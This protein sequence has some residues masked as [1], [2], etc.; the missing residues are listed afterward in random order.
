VKA[1]NSTD[2]KGF[3]QNLVF[4]KGEK[5]R[6]IEDSKRI[7]ILSLL[8][9]DMEDRL[10]RQIEGNN[11]L[12]YRKAELPA[13]CSLPEAI[14]DSSFWSLLPAD[15]VDVVL[16]AVTGPDMQRLNRKVEEKTSSR[17]LTGQ[18][19]KETSIAVVAVLVEDSVHD[20]V[21][22]AKLDFDGII[23]EPFLAR[24]LPGI[25]QQAI[26]R[27]RGR[28]YITSRYRR[29]RHLFRN[30]NRN[31]RQ[32]RN[33]MD[34]LCRD[35]VQSNANLTNTLHD[36]RRIYNFQSDLTG[37]FDLCYMLHK[38]LRQI[39]EQIPE[40]SA[41]VYLC[42]SDKIEAHISG[43]WYDNRRDLN[44]I[45]KLLK[46]TV[47]SELITSGRLILTGDAGACEKIPPKQRK[48][49]A[50]LSLMA[51]PLFLDN[52]LL[53][54]L[55]VYR[56]WSSPLTVS[57]SNFVKPYLPPLARAIEAIQKLNSLIVR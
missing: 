19:W 6:R 40:S 45:E 20:A 31:R 24:Q 22:A 36:L 39:K 37:E 38:A 5:L 28:H 11:N 48:E 29:M 33:K 17:N 43:P 25:F 7:N 15:N 57:E 14:I 27:S 32:L 50:G 42:S 16:L 30:V 44:E 4:R 9:G 41:V 8:N 56:N 18:F 49:L 12:C 54:G 10:R 46:E 34:L 21:Q 13:D 23:A 52:E 47:I 51:L 55:V 2:S 26:E 35:L 53:G 1:G 3:R